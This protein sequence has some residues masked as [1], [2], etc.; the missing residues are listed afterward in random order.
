MVCAAVIGCTRK[1]ATSPTSSTETAVDSGTEIRI[2]EFGS[3][4]GSEATFGVSTHK[5]IDLVI[6]EVNAAGGIKGKQLKLITYDNQGKPEEAASVV[7]RLVTQDKVIALLGEV[8]STRSLA[9]APIEENKIPMISP[10][11]TNPKV[12]EVGDYVFRVCFID[13]FQ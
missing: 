11:S 13:P 7:K 9:A 4:T 10:S 12:T 3:M 6:Q 5:G 8:A 1:D 2:G